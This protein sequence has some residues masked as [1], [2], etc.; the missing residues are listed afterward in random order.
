MNFLIIA[1]PCPMCAS[2]S[3]RWGYGEEQLQAVLG[4]IQ[5]PLGKSRGK[6]HENPPNHPKVP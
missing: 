4:W 5:A 2:A 1:R 6:S 3:P